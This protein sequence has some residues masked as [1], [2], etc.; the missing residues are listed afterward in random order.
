VRSHKVITS[1]VAITI[2]TLIASSGQSQLANSA[3]PQLRQR[4]RYL[5]RA[6]DT[7]QLQYRLTPDLDQT[8]SVQPDGYVDLNVAGE[9]Q[10][11]GLTVTQAH[12]LIV[13]KESEHLNNPELNLILEEFTRP[14]VVV[15]GE[16]AKPGQIEIRDNMTALSA[17]LLSGGFTQSAKS[18][19][20]IVFR[21]VNDTI[22]EVKQL[23]LTRVNKTVQ[24][25]K[26]IALQ[27][28]DLIL[29]P[30]DKVS[31][32]QHYMQIANVGVFVNPLQY[33][34]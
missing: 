7:L 5:L 3:Q 1:F 9:V 24:L 4:P 13:S 6:G 30:H 14:Y 21:K 10:V 12:D 34:P 22:D 20:V 31:R 8:V 33:I 2:A 15:A 11:A 25:E 26:D 23:N 28:G 29:V 19:Q 32:L 27:P 17:I 18:G 16:V